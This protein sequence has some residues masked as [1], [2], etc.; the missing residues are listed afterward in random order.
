MRLFIVLTLFIVSVFSVNAQDTG[1]IPNDVSE[2][3]I[4]A[5]L[6][7]RGFD[8]NNIDPT[9][10]EEFQAEFEEVVAELEKEKDLN[11]K[12]DTEDFVEDSVKE[13]VTTKSEDSFDKADTAEEIIKDAKMTKDTTDILAKVEDGT[14][15]EEAVSEKQSEELVSRLDSVN[16]YG[17][18]V[19]FNSGLK[20]FKTTDSNATPPNYVLSSGDEI[21][22]SIFGRSQVDLNYTIDGAGYI[23]AK[24]VGKIYLKGLNF[25][26]AEQL[27]RKRF[28][29]TYSFLPEQF[30][31]NLKSART[32]S[33]SIYGEVVQ[34][35]T[36]NVSALNSAL[37][38]LLAAGGPLEKGSVRNIRLIR[39]NGKEFVIDVYEFLNNPKS[40]ENLVIDNNDIIHVPLSNKVVH[41]T[42]AVRRPMRYELLANETLRDLVDYAGGATPD[43][44]TQDIFIESKTSNGFS[45]K[46]T[47]LQNSSNF[48]LKDLDVVKVKKTAKEKILRD[49]VKIRGEV[50]YPGEYQFREGITLDEVIKQGALTRYAR[51]DILFIYRQGVDG[52]LRLEKVD[53]KKQSARSIKLNA[54]DLVSI[55]SLKSYQDTPIEISIEG[56]VRNP[57]SIAIKDDK[58]IRVSDM[59]IIAGGLKNN[60]YSK[61]IITRFDK[62]NRQWIDYKKIDIYDAINNENS[63]NNIFLQEGDRVRIF[64]NEYFNDEA[65]SVTIQG[66]VK[67]PVETKYDESLTLKDLLL[68]SGGLNEGASDKAM[69]KRA[70]TDNTIDAEYIE[71]NIKDVKNGTS[72]FELKPKDVITVYNKHQYREQFDVKVIGEVNNP[73]V[74]KYDKTLTLNNLIYMSGGLTPKAAGNNVNI[75]RVEFRNNKS[76]TIL[77]KRLKIEKNANGM[78]VPDENVTIAPYDIIIIRPIPDYRLQEVVY[79]K[80]EVKY[81]GPYVIDR[82]TKLSKLVELAG[83]LT[84]RAFPLGAT[85]D[86]RSVDSTEVVMINLEKALKHKN[87]YENITLLPGDQLNIPRL[88]NTVSIRVENTRAFREYSDS[89]MVNSNIQISYQGKKSAKWYIENFAGGFDDNYDRS[90]IRVIEPGGRVRSTK[91]RFWGYKYPTVVEGSTIAVDAKPIK[92]KLNRSD[93]SPRLSDMLKEILAITSSAVTIIALAR[94]INK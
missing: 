51:K 43:A 76:N 16:I 22:V 91:R 78:Y 54:N 39:A 47:N 79:V 23:N 5:R 1:R 86:R 80:G 55:L 46:N 11:S 58:K 92:L 90:S 34:P 87:K 67:F 57:T 60:A 10:L 26:E 36:Y 45:V 38:V 44:N 20:F 89:L 94:T 48:K 83:G 62:K 4:R 93:R 9:K 2:A 56:A 52:M 70:R 29:R 21:M 12:N 65:Y 69:V 68:L 7:K 42:G 18:N 14:S 31:L 84:E 53:L 3:E 24:R 17:H 72:D 41:I 66:D 50:F 25:T 71:I 82:V 15:V 30:K 27:L 73:G 64:E 35:G 40:V 33:I 85:L 19:F 63:E 75:Y 88:K 32:I 13:M 61:A 28:R 6:V 77:H 37:N 49:V 74:Y 59:I 8:P 81:P